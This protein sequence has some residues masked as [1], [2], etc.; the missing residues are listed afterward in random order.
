MAAEELLLG[1]ILGVIFFCISLPVFGLTLYVIK[2]G[3][4]YF[5]LWTWFFL[6]LMSLV[7][8]VYSVE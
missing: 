4:A 5:F 3:G 7:R 2:I 6:F 1:M 8:L